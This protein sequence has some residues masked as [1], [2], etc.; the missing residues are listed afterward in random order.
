MLKIEWVEIPAGKFMM[1]LSDEQKSYLSRQL[2]EVY[3]IDRLSQEEQMVLK[4]ISYKKYE[5]YTSAERE[6][7]ES[8]VNADSLLLAYQLAILRLNHVPN[9]RIVD[10]PTFYITR[11]PITHSQATFFYSSLLAQRLGWSDEKR[12]I[13]DESPDRPEMFI[14]WEQAD[15]LAHWLGGRLPTIAEW[16]KAARGTDGRLYPWGNDWNPAA[17]NFGTPEC[18]ATG[19]V[20]KRKGRVTAADA[21]PEGSSPYGLIDL[22][23]NL[24]EWT[25]SMD[26]HSGTPVY[27]GC[28]IKQMPIEAPWFWA[29]PVHR[30]TATFD[31]VWYVGCRPVL[32]QWGQ[33]LWPGYRPELE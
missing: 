7:W 8:L 27:M 14:Y 21:Y 19:D 28:S 32:T 31:S 23:G 33:R 30:Y 6:Y 5:D 13:D 2:R 18:R 4:E 29:L 15:V 11:F 1:G 10:V 25:A 16:E 20:E 3:G 22:V 26:S 12:P 24:S 9:Q 17:G